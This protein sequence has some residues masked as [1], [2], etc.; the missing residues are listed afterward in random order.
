M[1]SIVWPGLDAPI[2]NFFL[3]YKL[4]FGLCCL[5]I[6]KNCAFIIGFRYC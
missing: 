2:T 3:D 4:K 6:F 1:I 5:T